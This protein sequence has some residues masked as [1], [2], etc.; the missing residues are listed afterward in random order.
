MSTDYTL[1]YG[2]HATQGRWLVRRWRHFWTCSGS[3]L[4][5]CWTECCRTTPWAS[6]RP[7]KRGSSAAELRASEFL[8]PVKPAGAKRSGAGRF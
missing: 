3:R 1:A 4:S 6:R 2:T 8:R 7:L 5:R